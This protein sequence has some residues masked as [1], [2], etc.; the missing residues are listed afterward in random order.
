MKNIYQK[1]ES[2]II[3][4]HMRA[5]ILNTSDPYVTVNSTAAPIDAAKV[6]SRRGG[7]SIWDDEEEN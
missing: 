1:P 2:K 5:T 7:Y 6:E 3:N 4:I